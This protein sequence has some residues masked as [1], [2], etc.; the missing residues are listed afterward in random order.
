MKREF[1]LFQSHIDLAP[2]YWKQVLKPGDHAIDATCGNGKDTLALAQLLFAHSPQSTLI[3]IDIQ[4]EAIWRTRALLQTS[5]S[6]EENGRVFLYQ[7]SHAAFP[8]YAYQVPIRLIVYNF[9]YLPSGDKSITT[10]ANSSLESIQAALSLLIAGGVISATCYPGHSQG[11]SEQAALLAYVRCLDP[12]QW[13][14]SW[15]TWP[16]RALSPTLLLIQKTA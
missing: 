8:E 5:L 14:V 11:E 12:S 16:N 10:L 4:S 15:H 9:G 1:P 6:H 3:G 7:Q 13:S 2:R